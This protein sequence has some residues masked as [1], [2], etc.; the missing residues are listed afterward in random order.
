MYKKNYYLFDRNLP[1]LQHSCALLFPWTVQI[2]SKL[3]KIKAHYSPEGIM[4]NFLV[5]I[6][7][8]P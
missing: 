7:P 6:G 3:D 2:L 5:H 8:T 4:M 1:R